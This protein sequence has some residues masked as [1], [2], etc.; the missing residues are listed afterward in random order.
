MGQ[1]IDFTDAPIPREV[2]YRLKIS[3]ILA[4][5]LWQFVLSPY[6]KDMQNAV[7]ISS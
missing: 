4:G 6:G 2:I 7:R 1:Q 3:S 5:S